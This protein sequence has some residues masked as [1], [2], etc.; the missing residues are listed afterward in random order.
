MPEAIVRQWLDH[1]DSA[2]IRPN[3]HVAEPDIRDAIDH[4][5]AAERSRNAI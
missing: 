4:F 1:V 3:S 5:C 2:V